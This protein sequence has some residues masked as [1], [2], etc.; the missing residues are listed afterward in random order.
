[1]TAPDDLEA[2]YELISKFREG[3]FVAGSEI[4]SHDLELL[5]IARAD[6]LPLE[7]ELDLEPERLILKVT[8]EDTRWN[9]RSMEV[10]DEIYSL[11]EEKK[12]SEAS[13]L[14]QEFCRECPSRWYQEIV[15]SVLND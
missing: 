14:G 4:S 8:E 7:T 10:I 13:L 3:E 6:L 15:E 9:H 11:L 1:M 12:S 5:K 2:V